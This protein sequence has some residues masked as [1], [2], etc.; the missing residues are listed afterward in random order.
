[1]EMA[2]SELPAKEE[3]SAAEVRKALQEVARGERV[4]SH[5]LLFLENSRVISRASTGIPRARSG[6]RVLD[7]SRTSGGRRSRDIAHARAH[8]AFHQRIQSTAPPRT[9]HRRRH[10]RCPRTFS[11]LPS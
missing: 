7:G 4:R 10:G 11:L 3:I 6:G 1:V 9:A 8:S 2:D 5:P